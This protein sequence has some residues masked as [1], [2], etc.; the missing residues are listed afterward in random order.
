MNIT[1]QWTL[2]CD[3]DKYPDSYSMGVII[4]ILATIKRLCYAFHFIV[5]PFIT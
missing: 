5:E 2:W 4:P 1:D 3:G